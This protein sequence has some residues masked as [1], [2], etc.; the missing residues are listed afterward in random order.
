M[1]GNEWNNWHGDRHGDR[2]APVN[3]AGGETRRRRGKAA[4]EEVAK[5]RGAATHLQAAG[6]AYVRVSAGNVT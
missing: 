5:V 2:M 3:V 6:S 4:G 1:E